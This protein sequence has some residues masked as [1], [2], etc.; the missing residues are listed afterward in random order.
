MNWRL[1]LKFF[2]LLQ[3][4]FGEAMKKVLKGIKGYKVRLTW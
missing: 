4:R 2:V 1:V 3:R